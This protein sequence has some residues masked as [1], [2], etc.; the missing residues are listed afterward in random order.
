MT[1]NAPSDARI[2]LLRRVDYLAPLDDEELVRLV[3]SGS[4][5]IHRP[6]ARIVT[7]LEFGADVF[8][9]LAG[10]AEVSVEPRAGERRVLGT[11]GPGCA[12]GEMSSITG[13][14][15]SATVTAKTRVEVLRIADATFDRLRERRPEVAVAVVRVLARRLAEAETSVDELFASAFVTGPA[16]IAR[17]GEALRGTKGSVGRAWREYVQARGKDLAFLALMA[18][19]LTLVL[20]RAIVGASFH[21]DFAPR[22]VLRAAYMTGFSLLGLSATASLFTFRPTWRRA[23]AFGYGAACALIANTLGVTLAFD[24]FFKD[25]HTADPNVAFD[26]E[27]LYRRT[28]P[29][30]AIVV[31]LVVLVQLAYLREFYRRAA[32]VLAT[33][34][35]GRLSR[36]SRV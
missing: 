13:A 28:E 32:F 26:I 22:H 18:F 5:E 33:R 8:V 9:V 14:L 3:A 16:P 29:V 6:G 35:R 17:G 30:R 10:D 15:R 23:I 1:D 12:L 27:R 36:Q 11:L 2:D 19:V 7:E 4:V 31:A 34:I 21:F 25:I 20:V 24:I